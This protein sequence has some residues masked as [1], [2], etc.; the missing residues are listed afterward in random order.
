MNKKQKLVLFVGIFGLSFWVFISSILFLDY[1]VPLLIET[2]D[3]NP[4]FIRLF[5]WL[6]LLLVSLILV[7]VG[8]NDKYMSQFGDK[9]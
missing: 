3:E 6:C 4:E 2:V 9:S 1:S 5:L 7:L 8:L